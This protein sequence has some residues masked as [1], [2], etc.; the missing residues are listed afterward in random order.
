MTVKD[1]SERLQNCDPEAWVTVWDGEL[2]L[3]M[4]IEDIDNTI[5]DGKCVDIN[6]SQEYVGDG[7]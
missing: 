6:L 5:H 7:V 1:L 2:G 3:R 4:E